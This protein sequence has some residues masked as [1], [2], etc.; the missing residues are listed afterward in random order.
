MQHVNNG[1][2]LPTFGIARIGAQTLCHIPAKRKWADIN[3]SCRA[4][5]GAETI[6]MAHGE[7]ERAMA[8]HAQSGDCAPATVSDGMI[9]P[10]HPLDQFKGNKGLISERAVDR[11]VPIPASVT[12]VRADNHETV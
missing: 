11:A 4:S 12:S 7:V 2:L 8:T 3:P 1:M 9:M 5:S 10:V 6:Q